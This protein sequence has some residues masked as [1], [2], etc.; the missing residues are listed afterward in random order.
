MNNIIPKQ[1]WDQLEGLSGEERADTCVNLSYAEFQSSNY[2]AAQ[3][4]CGSALDIYFGLGTNTSYMKI[5][6]AYKGISHSLKHLGKHEEAAEIS[7]QAANYLEPFD[8][9]DYTDAL[10]YAAD[11]YYL[12]DN[13]SK[14]LEIYLLILHNPMNVFEEKSLSM[15]F[16]DIGMCYKDLHENQDAITYLKKARRIFVL[17]GEPRN[18]AFV[19]EE[20]AE[21]FVRLENRSEALKYARYCLD[22][23]IMMNEKQRLYFS[24]NRMG[25]AKLLDLQFDAAVGHFKRSKELLSSEK[26][27]DLELLISCEKGIENAFRAMGKSVEAEVIRKR[28]ESVLASNREID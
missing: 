13:L 15:L 26:D 27:P 10:R 2:R 5:G 16:I 7:L 28:V 21:C 11:S 23:A 12:S 8:H 20:I 18:V 25:Y 19:D 3:I 14:A 6:E 4:L 24:H 9:N 1:I 22:Y 17:E